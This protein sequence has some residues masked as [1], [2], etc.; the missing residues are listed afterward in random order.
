MHLPLTDCIADCSDIHSVVQ[1]F[2]L[3]SLTTE[4]PKYKTSDI[5]Q[6]LTYVNSERLSVS[7]SEFTGLL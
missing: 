3:G 1:A 7:G 6:V 4:S 2:L 5:A